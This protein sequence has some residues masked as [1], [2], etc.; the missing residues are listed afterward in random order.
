MSMKLSKCHNLF[1]KL[2]EIDV[3][4]FIMERILN[5]STNHIKHIIY[6]GFNTTMTVSGESAYILFDSF[7]IKINYI[8]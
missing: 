5:S 7:L 4:A 2:P 8:R 6:R 3:D 1:L